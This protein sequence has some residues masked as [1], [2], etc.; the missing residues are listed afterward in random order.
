MNTFRKELLDDIRHTYKEYIKCFEDGRLADAKRS[1]D[2]LLM[3]VKT[4][5]EELT[6]YGGPSCYQVKLDLPL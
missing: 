4:Y 1:K 2:I 6:F 3:L 5:N